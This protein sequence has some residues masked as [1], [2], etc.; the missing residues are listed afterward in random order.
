M[1]C[2]DADKEGVM[3]RACIDHNKTVILSLSCCVAAC[4]LLP[5]ASQSNV[6]IR[7]SL[8]L[9]DLASCEP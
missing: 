8:A 4:H 7:S 6:M 9:Y 2:N 3:H 1:S 5:R